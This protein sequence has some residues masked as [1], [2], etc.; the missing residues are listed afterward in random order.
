[1]LTLLA[2]SAVGT[3]TYAGFL[4]DLP[5]NPP[6][7]EPA[8]TRPAEPAPAS[9]PTEPSPTA[10]LVAPANPPPPSMP[11]P[12]PANPAPAPLPRAADASG[13]VWEHPDPAFLA[14]FIESRN[15]SFAPGSPAYRAPR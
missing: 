4:A 1:M 9:A 15:R 3:W 5:P 2:L 11:D 6:T 10:P 13:Q 14:R 12:G 8:A 7:P